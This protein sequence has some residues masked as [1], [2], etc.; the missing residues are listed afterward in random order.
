MALADIKAFSCM[1]SQITAA[2]DWPRLFL[3]RRCFCLALSFTN[4]ISPIFGCLEIC[5]RD[6]LCEVV[7]SLLMPSNTLVSTLPRIGLIVFDSSSN[8]QST[9]VLSPLLLIIYIFTVIYI[10]WDNSVKISCQNMSRC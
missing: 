2:S 10:K 6:S 4:M 7:N 9:L 3:H 5:D 8:T 1:Y